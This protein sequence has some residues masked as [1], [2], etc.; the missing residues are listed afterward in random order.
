[1]GSIVE[2]NGT[3]FWRNR[4]ATEW[5]LTPT[6]ME[7][8]LISDPQ[9]ASGDFEIVLKQDNQTGAFLPEVAG[10][11][12]KNRLLL[13]IPYPSHRKIT[14]ID[15]NVYKTI[16][17]GDQI[18]MAE[19]LKVTQCNDGKALQVLN[20]GKTSSAAG[21]YWHENDPEKPNSKA[22][23]PLYNW[24]AV[25]DCNVCP[26]GW[27]VPSQ[28]EW[29]LLFRHWYNQKREDGS[30]IPA[31]P[32]GLTYA[33]YQLREEGNTYWKN[34]SQT[35]NSS[36]FSARPGGWLSNG[37]FSYVGFRTAWWAPTNNNQTPISTKIADGNKG[38]WQARASTND[39]LYIRCVKDK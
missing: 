10:L 11:R 4:N 8:K 9:S 35:T 34:N 21:M 29:Q 1:L 32:E 38:I 25:K 30:T 12:Y 14:D 5:M 13:K 28:A 3:Y 31:G 17:V 23:G 36:G 33:A 26:T 19:N 18:W 2:K 15:G 22:Y 27:H 7:G 20:I 39:M 6:L 16:V 24:A 37:R